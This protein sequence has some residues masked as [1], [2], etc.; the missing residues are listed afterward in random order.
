[1]PVHR[2]GTSGRPRL[3][4][5]DRRRQLIGAGLRLLIATPIHQLSVDDVAAEVGIS[6]SL[7]FHYFPTKGDYYRAV[8]QAAGG[9][10]VAS[11]TPAPDVPAGRRLAAVV[12]G[13]IDFIDRRRE[14]YLA[15]VR[16]AAA[17]P[18]LL[19][20]TDRIREQLVDLAA[21]ALDRPITDVQRLQLRGWLAYAQELVVAW[22]GHPQLDRD[23][24]RGLL[25]DGLHRLL[26]P[27]KPPVVR[28]GRAP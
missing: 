12:D 16:G 10:F 3:S 23:S 27:E 19:E 7:L 9:R 18:V 21:A 8:V 25:I 1:M 24:L 6:R 26:D 22:A 28:A 15:F 13:L 14:P 11:C 20:A 2:A 4:A 17:D 5:E